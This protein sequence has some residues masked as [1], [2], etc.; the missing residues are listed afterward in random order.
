MRTWIES[1]Y[2]PVAAALVAISLCSPALQLGYIL[3]DKIHQAMLRPDIEF[4]EAVEPV[5]D[6]FAFMD[7]TPARNRTF[8][9]LGIFPWW[10]DLQLRAQF[11]RPLSALTHVFDH[12][13]APSS[14]RFAHLHSLLWLGLCVFLA[15]W[16]YRTILGPG[17]A[18]FIATLLFAVDDAHAVPTAWLANRNGLIAL[19]FGLG[20]IIMH[21]RGYRGGRSWGRAL[22]PPLLL[23]AL[24]SAEAGIGAAAYLFA[25]AFFMPQPW[26]RLARVEQGRRLLSLVPYAAVIMGWKIFHS[27]GGYG[28]FGSGLYTDPI[29]EPAT[30]LAVLMTRAP[31]LFLAQWTLIPAE[32]SFLFEETWLPVVAVV[33]AL[34]SGGLTVWVWRAGS[35]RARSGWLLTGALLATIPIA[36][37]FPSNRLLLFVGVGVFGALGDTLNR[38]LS[39]AP[40]GWGAR[41]AVVLLIVSHGVVA[42]I[43]SLMA[44]SMVHFLGEDL[45]GRCAR[46]VP[47]DAPIDDQTFVFINAHMLCAGYVAPIRVLA[48]ATAPRSV[49]VLASMFSQVHVHRPDARTLDVEV[50]RG[51]QYHPFDRLMRRVDRP[52]PVSAQVA[53]T[54]MRAEV[55]AHREGRMHVVRFTFNHPLEHPSLRF[56][57]LDRAGARP[58]ALPPI[59]GTVVIPRAF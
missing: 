57:M 55:L 36:A 14:A 31:M 6:L 33:A 4:P 26:W 56:F 58:F 37:V 25:Y 54:D 42:P 13:V 32:V 52:L 5:W 30:F 1:P 28:A 46:A 22:A 47:N 3:D 51:Y 44:A 34:I 29:R 23:G 50:P 43:G 19:A 45:A 39:G 35:D 38:W 48:D 53:L 21:D 2:V 10:T 17:R 16:L 40:R 7:G 15:G 20:A 11:F 9:E 49:R 41:A 8:M 24:L 12:T 59:G 18:A 27:L